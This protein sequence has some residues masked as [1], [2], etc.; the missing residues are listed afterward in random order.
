M[1]R[2]RCC[3]SRCEVFRDRFDR[4]GP[5]QD[6]G[7]SWDWVN[8]NGEWWIDGSTQGKYAGDSALYEVTGDGEMWGPEA[9]ENDDGYGVA[10]DVIDE[11]P[12]NRYRIM[13]GAPEDPDR[14]NVPPLPGADC[15][16]AEYEVGEYRDGDNDGQ[17]DP[18][19][20]VRIFSRYNGVETL[21]KEKWLPPQATNEQN[22]RRF[23]AWY[24]NTH[25]DGTFCVHIGSSAYPSQVTVT[26][27]SLSGR[28]NGVGNRSDDQL[29][30]E[31]DDYTID[32]AT[33]TTVEG[34]ELP[35]YAC[36]CVCY[37]YIDD[38]PTKPLVSRA[39][40]PGVFQLRISGRC[41]TPFMTPCDTDDCPEALDETIGLE[42]EDDWP[43]IGFNGWYNHSALELCGYPFQ[44][45][46]ECDQSGYLTLAMYYEPYPGAGWQLVNQGGSIDLVRE[47]HTCVPMYQ[48]WR[49]TL[50]S[51][52]GFPCCIGCTQGEYEIEIW[53]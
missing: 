9:P 33:W 16:I 29:P 28:Y 46:L 3:C 6:I 38:D 22:G 23:Y 5:R 45:R 25:G 32:I 40:F 52:S 51:L 47:E 1:G 27:L 15:F 20:A 30:I 34:E 21:L 11:L 41:C 53:A 12:G 43:S 37:D 49:L 10:F 48:L 14:P 26:G 19:S 44:F 4:G 24:H 42:W 18:T 35:C 17:P 7:L 8:A 31:V 2:R 39:L 36:L 50:R 13:F